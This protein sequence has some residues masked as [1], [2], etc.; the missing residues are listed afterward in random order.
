MQNQ[1]SITGGLG[2]QATTD[3]EDTGEKNEW[4]WLR[5]LFQMV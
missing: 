2:I 1:K 4:W 3:E 5:T